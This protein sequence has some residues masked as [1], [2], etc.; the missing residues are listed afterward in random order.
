MVKVLLLVIWAVVVVVVFMANVAFVG[1]RLFRRTK[2]PHLAKPIVIP[3]FPLDVMEE[4]IRNKN[5]DIKELSAVAM[6]IAEHHPIEPKKDGKTDKAAK[7]L[8]ELIFTLAGHKNMT[9][10]M[11][12]D[13]YAKLEAANPSYKKEFDRAKSQ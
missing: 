8:L 3:D 7:H 9:G 2:R 10:E 4:I 11:R 12:S 13:M 1:T 6:A 5:S